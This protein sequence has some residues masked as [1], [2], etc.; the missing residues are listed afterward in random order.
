VPSSRIARCERDH[1]RANEA[2]GRVP[3][4]VGGIK[5]RRRYTVRSSHGISS[6]ILGTCD[7]LPEKKESC[8]TFGSRTR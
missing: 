5:M 4:Y 7:V 2:T 6:V 1:H 8:P 3:A